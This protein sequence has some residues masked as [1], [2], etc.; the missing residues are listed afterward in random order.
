MCDCYAKVNEKLKP[1]NTEIRASYMLD[2]PYTGM[3]WPVA[4][5]QIETGRGKKK[6]LALFA[7]FCP[8]C[9]ENQRKEKAE[10]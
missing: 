9:G 8:F 10:G 6:A 4:T 3:P 5:S 2:S 1:H 7:S